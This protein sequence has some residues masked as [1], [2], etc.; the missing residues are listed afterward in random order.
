MRQVTGA[1]FNSAAS[2]F[3]VNPEEVAHERFLEVAV[4]FWMVDYPQ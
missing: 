3:E 4:D 1:A 2:R